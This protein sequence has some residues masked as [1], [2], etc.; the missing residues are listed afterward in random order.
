MPL[1]PTKQ[2]ESGKP[3]QRSAV[4]R[5]RD[6]NIRSQRT[7]WREALA[8]QMGPECRSREGTTRPRGSRCTESCQGDPHRTS[9]GG[10]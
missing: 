5:P 4:S 10:L 8:R 1:M 9:T 3:A 6:R 7:T 2:I